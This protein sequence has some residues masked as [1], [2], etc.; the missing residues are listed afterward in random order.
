MDIKNK[1]TCS[2]QANNF[3]NAFQSMATRDDHVMTVSY[4]DGTTIL[5]HADGTRI[6][7]YYRETQVPVSDSVTDD[8]GKWCMQTF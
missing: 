8:G 6:T 5:E 3:G 7:T 4:P 1:C 2:R